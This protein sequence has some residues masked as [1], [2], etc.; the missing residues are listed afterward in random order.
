MIGAFLL[1]FALI[2]LV[3]TVPALH[4]LFDVQTLTL[5]QLFTVYGL[6]LLTLPVIQILK[7]IRKAW[8]NSH[9]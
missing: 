6:A 3:L 2:T 4:G 5:A 9:R 1:G 8:R 7:A